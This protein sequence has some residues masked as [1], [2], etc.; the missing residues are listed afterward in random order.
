MN[1]ILIIYKRKKELK[2]QN[3]KMKK[4]IYRNL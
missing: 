2:N 4:Q 3:K 1:F